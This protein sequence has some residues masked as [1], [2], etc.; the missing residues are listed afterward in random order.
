[1]TWT[2][3]AA[4]FT[5]WVDLSWC[6]VLMID[7]LQLSAWRAI[8]HLPHALEATLALLVVITEDNLASN[9]SSHLSLRQSYATAII[10]MVNGLV[11]PLQVGAYARSIASVANQLGLPAWLVELRHAATHEDL[12]SIELLREAA[13]EVRSSLSP[14]VSNSYLRAVHGLASSKLFSPNNQSIVPSRTKNSAVTP[15]EPNP[16]AV[17]ESPQNNHSRC[18]VTITVQTDNNLSAKGRRKMD[19]GG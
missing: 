16:Q 15:A 5:E 10:R 9:P 4:Q 2:Q 18:F 14:F 17:Q 19:I 8:T 13:R 1:M 11:D 3:N 12:P 6:S 7:A